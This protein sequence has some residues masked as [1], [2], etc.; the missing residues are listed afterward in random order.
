[1]FSRSCLT[2]FALALTGCATAGNVLPLSLKPG[3]CAPESLLAQ[4]PAVEVFLDSTALSADIADLDVD[5]SET[6]TAHVDLTL[7]FDRDGSNI[8]R[9]V[10]RHTVTPTLADSVQQLVFANLRKTPAADEPWGVRLK[11]DL[12]DPDHFQVARRIQCPPVPHDSDLRFAME[13]FASEAGGRH[14][15]MRVIVH[16]QGYVEDATVVRGASAGGT[17]ERELV[18]YVRRFFFDPATVDGLPV[19]GTI[20][21]PIRIR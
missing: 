4:L 8:H 20:V 2:L 1:M 15:L 17:F 11:V 9:I 3:Q 13:R 12:A 18:S 14:A 5:L 16:P 19:F 10:F 7:A 6:D 21:I